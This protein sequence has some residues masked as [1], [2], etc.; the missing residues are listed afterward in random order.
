MA[1]SIERKLEE[2]RRNK[3]SMT[4][5][6]KMKDDHEIALSA[7]NNNEDQQQRPAEPSLFNVI[8][9]VLTSASNYIHSTRP[10]Q[11]VTCQNIHHPYIC[12][13]IKLAFWALLW[14]WFIMQGFGTIFL[15]M[16]MF[17]AIYANLGTGGRND[18]APSAYSVFNKD[19]ERIPGTFSAEQLERELIGGVF[20]P[21]H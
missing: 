3:A 4:S 19:F 9:S 15:I 20:I 12:A 5:Q 21:A 17:Y 10:V 2:Y 11:L 14:T 7:S 8:K 13:V 18:G 1:S 16:S 6:E